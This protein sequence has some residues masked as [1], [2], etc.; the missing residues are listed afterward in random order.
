MILP[1]LSRLHPNGAWV[2]WGGH[3]PAGGLKYW[4]FERWLALHPESVPGIVE[5]SGSSTALALGH[6]AKERGVPFTAVTDPNGAKHLDAHGFAGTIDVCTDMKDGFG[7]CEALAAKGW[8]WPRQLT[9]GALA[10]AVAHWARELVEP[11]RALGGARTILTGFGTGCTSV[12][13]ARVL[14]PEGFEVRALQAAPGHPV[15]GWRHFETQNLG[16]RDAFWAHRN[17]ITRDTAAEGP[18]ESAFAA[19]RAGPWTDRSDVVLV[20]HDAKRPPDES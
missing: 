10:D 19:L 8:L 17:E 13:L 7:R 5:M 15:P 11:L 16:E 12:G 3:S 2:L 6:L 4:T 18:H 20:A 9:N 14:G 1:P